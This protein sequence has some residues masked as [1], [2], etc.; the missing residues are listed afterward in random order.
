V[1]QVALT[2]GP[3]VEDVERIAATDNPVIRN[4]EITECYADLSAAVRGRTGGSADWCTF[5]TWASR[6]AGATIRGEDLLD[7]V[8]RIL[9]RRS[10]VV[11]PVAALSRLLLRKGLFQP[12]TTLGRV[13]AQ[14]HTPFDAFERASAEVAKGNLKV[15]AEIGREFARFLATVP[16]DARDDSPELLVFA[17]QLRPGA[18]PDGQDLLREAFAHYQR[19]RSEADPSERAAWILLANLKIG[20][21][22]QTRLQPQIAAAVAAPLTTAEALGARVLHVL[23]PGARQWPDRVHGAAAAAIGWI[24]ARVRREAIAVTQAAV[25]ESMMVLSLPTIVLSLGRNLSAPVPAILAGAPPAFLEAF[26]KEYD[27]C[28]PGGTAC[29]A[30]DWCDLRQRM[31]Y[32]VHLF[33]AYAD[34]STLFSRPFT[35]DQVAAFRAGSIPRGEL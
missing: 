19:Q 13:V 3:R 22:E 14:I 31:H 7:R 18:P 1:S 12:G 4:L 26:A 33:R 11:A 34:E 9:G 30:Q 17:A 5:A 23:I 25:T 10:W 35:P 16:P 21:H 32:I 2:T 29:A 24:A 6:Q 20:L 8:D 27:P 28:P 15:F